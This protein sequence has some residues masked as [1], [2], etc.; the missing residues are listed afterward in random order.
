MGTGKSGGRPTASWGGR[1]RPETAATLEGSFDSFVDSF[2]RR[3]YEASG[4]AL[5]RLRHIPN[6]GDTF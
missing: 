2:A 4:D 6:T 3:L 5:R 1:P